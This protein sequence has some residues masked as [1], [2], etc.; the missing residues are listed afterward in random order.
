MNEQKQADSENAKFEAFVK[1]ELGDIAVMD[2]GRYV[3][4]KINNYR[5]VWDA[6]RAQPV[7]PSDE[8]EV[9]KQALELG[10]D[11]ANTDLIMRMKAYKD[12]PHRYAPEA[13]QVRQIE[14]A[15]ASLRALLDE[16]GVCDES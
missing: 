1:A 3:S 16:G 7:A 9:L 8:R 4:P 13:Q 14:A 11:F 10:H 15:I 5:K 6:A 2:N 12:Y